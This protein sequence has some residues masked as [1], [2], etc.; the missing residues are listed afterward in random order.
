MD[1]DEPVAVYTAYRM[2][3]ELIA[4]NLWKDGIV[5]P[6]HTYIITGSSGGSS[7]RGTVENMETA[8]KFQSDSSRNKV[9]IGTITSAISYTATTARKGIVLGPEY[10]HLAMQQMVGRLDRANQAYGEDVDPIQFTYIRHK[11][12]VEEK[13]YKRV[14]ELQAWTE[15]VLNRGDFQHG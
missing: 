2:G 11:R 8:A 4:Q 6:Q 12:T 9:L 7:S 1:V 14:A 3:V 13:V 5:S 10:N 15:V